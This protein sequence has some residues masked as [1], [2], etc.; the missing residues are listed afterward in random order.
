MQ[1]KEREMTTQEQPA[2]KVGYGKGAASR[3]R[4]QVAEWK[5]HKTIVNV[6]ESLGDRVP[7]LGLS[8]VI[9]QPILEDG[10]E[11]FKRLNASIS[12]GNRFLRLN[13]KALIRLMD[14]F[15]EHRSAI[16]DAQDE[17]HDYNEQLRQTQQEKSRAGHGNPAHGG[18]G[19]GL[20]RFT[21][22]SKTEKRK[23]RRE[24]QR[25]PK[26]D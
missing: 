15:V 25:S 23:K 22:G 2:S 3:P 18:P 16:L 14:L 26:Q 5:T 21:E 10:T 9:D 20:S 17:V 11:R 19:N 1:E 24:H 7:E 8:I 13:T 12:L 6:T 4:Q